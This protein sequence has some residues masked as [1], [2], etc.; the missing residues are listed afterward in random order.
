[1]QG[2]INWHKK[3]ICSVA[4]HRAMDD[5]CN[6]ITK[7]GK[8]KGGGGGGG[9]KERNASS[10]YQ[11]QVAQIQATA[12]TAVDKS[13]KIFANTQVQHACRDN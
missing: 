9:K 6:K 8:V 2:K 13:A 5:I 12:A 4:L 3:D 10:K 1:M 7:Y 11:V